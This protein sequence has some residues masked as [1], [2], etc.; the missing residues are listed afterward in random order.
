MCLLKNQGTGSETYT[1][2]GGSSGMSVKGR[3]DIGRRLRAARVFETVFGGRHQR[4]AHELTGLLA[5]HV[6]GAF[7]AL[8]FGRREPDPHGRA[9]R[10]RAKAS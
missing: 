3:S 7:N 8:F 4:I 6:G 5:V 9:S 1:P 2:D 10:F